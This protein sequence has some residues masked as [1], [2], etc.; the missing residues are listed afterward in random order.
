MTKIGVDEINIMRDSYLMGYSMPWIS[1]K[2]KISTA[3]VKKYLNLNG[4]PSRSCGF[5]HPNYSPK[6]RRK[7]KVNENAFD[8]IETPDQ[9]Y[10]IGFLMADC[11]LDKNGEF[12]LRLKASDIL[13]VKKF[14]QF[15][16]STHPVKQFDAINRKMNKSYPQAGIWVHSAHLCRRLLSIGIIPNRTYTATLQIALPDEL[17]PHYFRG[18]VVASRTIIRSPMEQMRM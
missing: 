12:R 3:T 9:A 10:W 2:L 7:Y 15:L 13:H 6:P 14:A 18:L 4:V 17:I 11:T 8:L 5:R 1:R 16:G